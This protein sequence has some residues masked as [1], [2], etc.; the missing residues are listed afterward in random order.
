MKKPRP[1]IYYWDVEALEWDKPILVV[2]VSEAGDVWTFFGPDCMRRFSEFVDTHPGTYFAHYGGGY[3]VPLLLNVRGFPEIVLTGTNILA[4]RD[5][6]TV[7]RDT[8]PWFLASLAK[9]GEAIGL[10]KLDVD[11]GD[12]ESLSEQELK[13]YGTRDV[14]ILKGGVEAAK[15]FLAA[16]EARN[17]TTAGSSAV[18]LVRAL[19]PGTWRSLVRHRNS[20]EDVCAF[21]DD[22]AGR[23][24]RNECWGRGIYEGITS[25]DF[26]SSYPARY[27]SKDVGIGMERSTRRTEGGVYLGRWR[28]PHRNRIPP[29]VDFGSSCGYGDGETWLT[30]NEIRAF[31]SEGVSVE[32]VDGWIPE[33]F[34]PVAQTFAQVMFAAKE[35]S[36]PSKFFS[37]V[38]LNSWH[39]K[40]LEHPIKEHFT[41]WRPREYLEDFGLEVVGDRE[42][43]PDA[44]WF[45]WHAIE[46]ADDGLCEPYQQPCMGENILGDA[47]VALWS[48]AFR[49]LE[50]E[51]VPVLYG[52]TDSC[53]AQAKEAEIRSIIGASMGKT[54]GKLDV[55][56]TECVGYYLGPKAYLL[57]DPR[58][59][60]VKKQAMKGIPL[61]SYAKGT[62]DADGT[63]RE[64][65][66][67]E[68]ARDV[69][70]E[71]F[72]RALS[73]SSRCLKDGV[74]TFL[75]GAHGYED[76][77]GERVK[78]RWGRAPQVREVRPCGRGK[79]FVARDAGSGWSY[80]SVTEACATGILRALERPMTGERWEERPETARAYLVAVGAVRFVEG[81]LHRDDENQWIP[82]Y[83]V[84]RTTE[85]TRL[86]RELASI[87]TPETTNERETTT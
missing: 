64:A 11:R 1:S 15:A 24:G 87:R 75:R 67:G 57:V 84:E 40:A 47:R 78:S 30:E 68:I 13:D 70:V 33:T 52:D 27:A 46:V 34:L 38:F 4:A 81:P 22:A 82:T 35:G 44:S 26:K 17:A 83:H 31:E 41:R 73:S 76:K 53:H 25:L 42:G 79:S 48:E 37:K 36:G 50:R 85:G 71:L 77:A 43:R 6:A 23:G 51:G 54:L 59:G 49:P 19:E 80:V 62:I 18:S 55:E 61:K 72:E 63:F 58:T 86:L 3:D 10:P 60:E 28:W 69:R 45:R 39:G 7:F 8:F 16:H 65:R 2:V 14:M 21:L 32:I 9:I 74:S 66:K 56:A 12:I 29:A 20:V 5:G